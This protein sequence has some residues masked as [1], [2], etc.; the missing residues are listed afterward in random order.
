MRVL[1]TGANGLIGAALTKQLTGEGIE[2]VRL[3]RMRTLESDPTRIYWHPPTGTLDADRLQGFRTVVHLAG[4]NIADGPWT[5]QK[6]RRIF[7]SRVT[8]TK[9]LCRILA[10]LKEKPK[11]LICASAIGYYGDRGEEVLT[12][13]SESGAGFLAEVCRAWEE[14]ATPAAEAGIRVIHLRLGM[15]LSSRGGALPRMLPP[16]RLGAGGPVGGGR[17]W[18]SWIS[19]EDAVG[20]VRHSMNNRRAKGVLNAVAPNPIQNRDFART[21]GAVLHRPAFLPLPGW[22]VKL[23]LGDMGRELLLSS[24]RVMPERLEQTGYTWRYPELEDALQACVKGS[25]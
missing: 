9:L 22:A 1:I 18:M 2:T 24:A 3:T 4:E 25:V 13:S 8:G 17:Q 16:F 21:L 23:A 5:E 19:L 15:V 14:A 20:I 10:D 12:E 6:R 7:D 11:T